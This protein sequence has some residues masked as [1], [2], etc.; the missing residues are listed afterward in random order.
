MMTQNNIHD[1]V[2]IDTVWGSV[3]V[4]GHE[5]VSKKD[6]VILGEC[7]SLPEFTI[8]QAD[9]RVRSVVFRY[10]N[11]PYSSTTGRP[12]LANC[13]FDAGAICINLQETFRASKENALENPSVSVVASYHRNLILSFLHEIHHIAVLD[14]LPDKAEMDEAETE[15]EDWAW[16][17][18]VQLAQTVNIEPAHFS[19]CAFLNKKISILNSSDNWSHDQYVMMDNRVM[20]T[21]KNEGYYTFKGYIRLIDGG[22]ESDPK[23]SKTIPTNSQDIK[24]VPEY[25]L[26]EQVY[27][28]VHQPAP[29]PP[30][31]YEE[32]YHPQYNNN[33]D[34]EGVTYEPIQSS[35][36]QQ[37]TPQ[38]K[39]S[40]TPTPTTVTTITPSASSMM[41]FR[42]KSLVIVEVIK[43]CYA[44]IFNNC[45]FVGKKGNNSDLGFNNPETVREIGIPLTEVE[46]S[47]VVGIDCQD[48]NGY[49]CQLKSTSDGFIFG[50]VLKNTKLPVFKLFMDMGAG[51]N[52]VRFLLPQNPAAM[53]K[54]KTDYSYPAKQAKS[55]TRIMYIKEGDDAIIADNNEKKESNF[56]FKIINDV[57]MKA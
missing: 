43:K 7:L 6:L 55:G 41:S 15:A 36:I 34:D 2:L 19:E 56:Y 8:K 27:I 28:P 4:F 31:E 22:K 38:A 29:T 48:T 32:E 17:R 39:Q 52:K 16:A 46:R 51:I 23:W 12:I 14:G 42:D 30:I 45:G 25:K 47:I 20:Y 9:H 13:S 40:S 21:L 50:S 24:P 33:Y 26:D 10:D 53:N 11:R 57:Y 54:A 3:A 44:H 35:L 37:P 1:P 5:L 18:L 49:W